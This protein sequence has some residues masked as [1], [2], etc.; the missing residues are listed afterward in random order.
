MT[1][2]VNFLFVEKNGEEYVV[3]M[4]P[5]LQDD[6]GTVGFAELADKGA[7]EKDEVILNLEAAKTVLEVRSPLKGTIVEVNEAAED[8][9]TLLNSAE[10]SENWIVKLTDVDQAEYDSLE[11]A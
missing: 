1:K 7:I 5:E 2:R 6:V 11:E 10:A 8:T 4:T 3:R 9:P